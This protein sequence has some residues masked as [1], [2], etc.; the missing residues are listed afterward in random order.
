[1]T[2]MGAK[3]TYTFYLVNSAGQP[4]NRA[5][6]VIPF[7]EAFYVAD[8]VTIDVTWNDLEGSENMLAEN[9]LATAKVPDVYSLYDDEAYYEIR[10]YQTEDENKNYYIIE[11]AD[12]VSNKETT[13]VF[14][15]QAGT[16]F[17]EYGA[18]RPL[19]SA[20]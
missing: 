20:H 19:S 15:T 17:D 6:K 14:N 5:G 16:R 9:L 12:D 11:G 3:V 7:A 18:L 1:M 4:V 2:W 10:V 8:P 13:K